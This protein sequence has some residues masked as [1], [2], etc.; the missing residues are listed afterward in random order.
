[1]KE[2]TLLDEFLNIHVKKDMLIY[3]YCIKVMFYLTQ[4]KRK[5]F[6]QLL[7]NPLRCWEF[8]S[9]SE[10]ENHHLLGSYNA[11]Y[12][13]QGKHSLAKQKRKL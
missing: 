4:A 8:F 12:R 7:C 2:L 6:E 5:S 11:S 10:Q 13:Q 9:Y 3:F 1:M